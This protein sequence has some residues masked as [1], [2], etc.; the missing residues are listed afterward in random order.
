MAT[1]SS[2]ALRTAVAEAIA[3]F[4]GHPAERI[5]DDAH[6]VDDLGIDSMSSVSLLVAVEDRFGVMLPDGCEGR[7]V[8]VRTV[9]E[10]I[11]QLAA[12]YEV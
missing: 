8:P 10:L 5:S 6:L 4:T 12:I 9:G 11:E 2:R 7:L 3:E 1:Q